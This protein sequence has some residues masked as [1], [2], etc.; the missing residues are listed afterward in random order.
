MLRKK[1]KK[2]E[3]IKNTKP[4]FIAKYRKKCFTAMIFTGLPGLVLFFDI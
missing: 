4:V 1:I 3:Q 2:R